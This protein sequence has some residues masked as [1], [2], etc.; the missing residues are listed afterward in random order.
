MNKNM[1]K[2]YSMQICMI[3]FSLIVYII[4]ILVVSNKWSWTMGI[5]FGLIFSVL[6]YQLMINSFNKALVL[7]EAKAKNYATAQYMIRYV[8]TGIVL[9]IAA[10]EPSINLLG[11]FM[12]LLSMKVAAYAQYA[13]KDIL[14]DT[15]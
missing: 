6:K 14:K 9:V 4:G 12:G 5:A 3:L 10:L 8:L 1:L 13:L 7:P 11:V 2:K 15:N